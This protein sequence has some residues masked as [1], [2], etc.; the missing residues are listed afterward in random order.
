MNG[1]YL[2]KKGKVLYQS[3]HRRNH[4]SMDKTYERLLS[5][6]SYQGN[7]NYSYIKISLSV[8]SKSFAMLT[9]GKNKRQLV[10]ECKLVLVL[11]LHNHFK[12]LVGRYSLS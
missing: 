3:L 12:Q 8:I 5:I 10:L 2:V 6:I 1:K 11:R 7:E 9:V 4:I